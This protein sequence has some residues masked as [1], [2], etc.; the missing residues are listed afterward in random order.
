MLGF[1]ADTIGRDRGLTFPKSRWDHR[2]YHLT[3]RNE[4]PASFGSWLMEIG[5]WKP[6]PKA[7]VKKLGCGCS[8]FVNLLVGNR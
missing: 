6:N 1:A 7:L 4:L 8:E 2:L 5:F 3:I